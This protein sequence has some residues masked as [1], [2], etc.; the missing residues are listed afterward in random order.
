MKSLLIGRLQ[1]VVL[2][3]IASHWSDVTSGVPQGSVLGSLLFVLYINDIADVI[4]SD[5]G[6]FA[7]DTKIFSIIRDICD[8][9]RLPRDLNNMQE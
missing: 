4:Q 7:D 5:L 9:T 8:M 6:I 1:R 3:R 2:N